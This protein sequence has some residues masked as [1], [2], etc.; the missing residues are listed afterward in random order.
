M[1]PE[2][3]DELRKQ[4]DKRFDQFSLDEVSAVDSGAM[5]LGLAFPALSLREREFAEQYFGQKIEELR[6][7]LRGDENPESEDSK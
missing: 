1:T 4:I 7:R 5:T 2:R 6:G 3:Q